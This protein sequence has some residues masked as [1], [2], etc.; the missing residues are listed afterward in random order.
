MYIAYI[1]GKITVRGEV[2]KLHYFFHNCS[3][4]SNA[5]V[6]VSICVSV[7]VCEQ[8]DGENSLPLD[9]LI[10]VEYFCWYSE[11]YTQHK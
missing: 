5:I 11:L 4:E 6:F 3:S 9:N 8:D 1:G 2:Q 10:L 7:Y